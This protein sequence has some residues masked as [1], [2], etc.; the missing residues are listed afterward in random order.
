MLLG[1]PAEDLAELAVRFGQPA[2]RGQQIL[3]GILKGARCV[4]DIPVVRRVPG[5]GKLEW[6]GW[7][8]VWVV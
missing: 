7:G 5:E 2:F 4:E 8:E 3:D 1:R 6:N